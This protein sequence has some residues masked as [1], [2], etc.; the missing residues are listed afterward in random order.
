[1]YP[2]NRMSSAVR[3]AVTI[4]FACASG[5]T[6]AQD[7]TPI[8]LEAPSVEVVGSTP[9]PGLATPKD[10][11]PANIQVETGERMEEQQSLNLPE[12][13]EETMQ[14]IYVQDVQNNPYQPNLTYRGFLSSPLLGTPQGLSVYQDGV[15]I[16]EPFGDIV[17]YD[18]IPQNA[19]STMTLVPGSNPIFGLNTLGGAID[20][21][22]KSGAYY[23][24]V[25]ATLSGGSW[26][27]KQADIAYGGYNEKVDYFIAA[28]YFEE[29]GWRDFSPTEVAQLFGKVGWENGITDLDLAITLAD[30][31]LYGNGVTPE[32]FLAN[33]WE[34]I[35]T[36]PDNTQNEMAMANLTG[37]H[38]LDDSWLLSGV[39]YYRQNNAN[40]LNGDVNDDF[41]GGPN[42]GV[43]ADE[44]AVENRSRTEQDG[45]GIGLQAT[46]ALDNNALAFGATYDRSDSEFFQTAQEG[47]F[48]ATRGVMTTEPL[49]VEN[50]LEG[51][52][53]TASIYFTDTYNYSD[54]LALTFSGRYN[55]TN[56]KTTDK[57]VLTPP[58]L[59]GDHTYKKFNPAIGAT[60][61]IQPTL[62]TYAG[63]SQGSRAPSPIE[64]G[65]ADPNNPCTLPAGLAADPF[66]EQV[67]AQTIEAGFRG[68][69]GHGLSWNAGVFR[70]DS[71]DDILWVG[72]ST[73]AGYFTNF[74]ETRR[75]GLEAGISAYTGDRFRWNINYSYIDA[76]FE[77][78]ACLLQENNSSRGQSA[79]CYSPGVDDLIEVSPG[80]SIPAIPEHQ[81]RFSAD[82]RL[83]NNWSLGGSLVAFADSYA[84]GNENNLHQAGQSTDLG[85]TTRTFGGAGKVDGY[86]VINLNTRYELNNK[87][88]IF[89]KITN[90]FDER[91]S[92]TAILAENVFDSSGNFQI[93][94]NN[95]SSEQFNAPGA[96]RGLFVGVK[97][98][99][100][101]AARN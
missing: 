87:L 95:W 81:M 70:T 92:S 42:D 84:Y 4:M 35:Y 99:L 5:A 24:G 47:V 20:I 43:N 33:R 46:W 54:A 60:Y 68:R 63:W 15:R 21:R 17:N 19:I 100:G 11:V 3:A 9:V 78:S 56:V 37:T 88:E 83:T 96:P 98:R 28:N 27:R 30:T 25:D 40:T 14:S 77:S 53:D 82:Y 91:Y 76:T 86:A 67:V 48:D 62:T 80:Q 32:S 13:M 6:F 2:L 101:K 75:Q 74:G 58:N 23:P 85:G 41:E 22:T 89:G 97:Y 38:W 57:L 45:Y 10:E 73:S 52:T 90:L 55:H 18:L 79:A 44:S 12:F 59:D 93:D 65:C 64:L 1:M 26:G 72:T 94:S 69:M 34:S 8:N 49:T 50:I 36:H 61:K 7:E 71:E 31:D 16:N 66:L 51:T 39:T 29:D